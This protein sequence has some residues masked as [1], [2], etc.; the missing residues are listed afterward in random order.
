MILLPSVLKADDVWLVRET[1]A[2]G[3]PEEIQIQTQ[4]EQLPVEPSV[5]RQTDTLLEEA[6]ERA[7][8][9]LTQAKSEANQLLK[10]AATQ[11]ES[12]RQAAEQA[13]EKEGH[14][15]GY[16]AGYAEGRAAAEVIQ[17][18]A[19]QE[20]E[21]AL[22]LLES[23]VKSQVESQAVELITRILEK[24]VGDAPRFHPEIILHLVK[25][26]LRE[27]T[28]TGDITVRVSPADA[29][30]VAE[31][32]AEIAPAGGTQIEV[33][34]DASLARMDCLIETPIG[35]I[36]SSLEKQFALLKED[37]HHILNG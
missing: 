24:L 3:V 2:V 16:E 30:M 26:G 33:V 37:L 28:A 20:K 31:N 10:D 7:D 35:S 1:V 18:E 6:R 34:S 22:S 11:S 14:A 5:E 27:T 4:L 36:D 19:R 15:S 21:N 12:L 8:R 17:E 9:L 23:Q 13:A 29:E 32:I 25:S